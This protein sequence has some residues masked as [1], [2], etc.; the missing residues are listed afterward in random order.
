MVLKEA[1][2]LYPPAWIFS[3][4]PIEGDEIGGYQVPAETTVLISPYVTH[5]N[6]RYWK[7]PEVFDPERFSSTRAQGRPEFCYLPFGGGPRKC[8]GDRFAMTEGV[9]ILVSVAERYRLKPV[10]SH[11]VRPEPLVT[12]RPQKGILVT[13]EERK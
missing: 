5:R 6:P 1:M 12:L 13:L 9:L 2:R 10:V 7:K 8:I 3:R 4:R 11:P